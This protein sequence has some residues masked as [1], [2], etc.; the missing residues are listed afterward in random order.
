MGNQINETFHHSEVTRVSVMMPNTVNNYELEMWEDLE[1]LCSVFEDLTTKNALVIVSTITPSDR[2]GISFQFVTERI[3][4]IAQLHELSI[5]GR[6]SDN[7]HRVSQ[8][9]ATNRETSLPESING[10]GQGPPCSPTGT[11]WG[12]RV[13]SQRRCVINKVIN[14]DPAE[15]LQVG[16]NNYRHFMEA[17]NLPW[18]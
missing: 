16:P 3:R 8:L 9:A 4:S 14:R 2:H 5:P 11:S 15:E 7:R 17:W 10:L 6:I 12:T 13:R 18:R 1:K